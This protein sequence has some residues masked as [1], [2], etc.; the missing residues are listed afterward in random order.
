[1]FLSMAPTWWTAPDHR[2]VGTGIGEV[3]RKGLA[4]LAGS[5]HGLAFSESLPTHLP[6]HKLGS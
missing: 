4:P 6:P 3:E 1:M 2:G 5:M